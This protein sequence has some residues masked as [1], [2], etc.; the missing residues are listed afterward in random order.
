MADVAIPDELVTPV[1][2]PPAKL[3]LAPLDGTLKVTVSPLIG[4]PSV[5]LSTTAK[6]AAKAVRI[7]ALCGVPLTV[8]MLVGQSNARL[9][10]FTLPIPVAKSHPRFAVNAGWSCESEMESTPFGPAAG[11]PKK[12]LFVPVQFTSVSP[13]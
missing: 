4:F 13:L 10:A 5:S 2:T 9:Y 8:A 12:Q 7:V 11:F 1:F 3:P 6:G